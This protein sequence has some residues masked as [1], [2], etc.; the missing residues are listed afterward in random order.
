MQQAMQRAQL[1]GVRSRRQPCCSRRSQEQQTQQAHTRPVKSTV[2]LL[3][4]CARSQLSFCCMLFFCRAGCD[5]APAALLPCC[6]CLVCF[7]VYAVKLSMIEIY[8]E[9]LNDLLD[10]SK[11]NLDVQVQGAWSCGC[12]QHSSGHGQQ[13]QLTAA[14]R[15]ASHNQRLPV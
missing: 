15:S 6:C 2:W 1:L 7:S 12:W 3:A 13:L 11:L 8:C 5:C 9:M 10:S 14:D 4:V